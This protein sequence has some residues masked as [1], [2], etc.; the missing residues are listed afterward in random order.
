MD[1]NN[2]IHCEEDQRIKNEPD[3]PN[4]T[5]NRALAKP[6]PDGSSQYSSVPM[7]LDYGAHDP[8]C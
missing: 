5:A 7:D 8:I 4:R 6:L 2:G 3:H 1:E